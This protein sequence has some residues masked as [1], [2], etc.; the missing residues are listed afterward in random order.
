MKKVHYLAFALVWALP[1]L[2][3]AGSG[4]PE[5]AP[6]TIDAIWGAVCRVGN[7]VFAFM[8]VAAVIA[9]IYAGYLF[10]S[11]GGGEKVNQAKKTLMYAIIGTAV[12]LLSKTFIVI[13]GDTLGVDVGPFTCA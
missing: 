6:R 2:A 11:S 9:F 3:L 1:L 10:F 7:W 5:N 4:V 13:I 12:T 8:L